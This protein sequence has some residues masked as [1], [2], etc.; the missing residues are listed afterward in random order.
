VVEAVP[1]D[2]YKAWVQRMK[3]ASAEASDEGMREWSN[4]EL[5]ARGKDVYA[6]SCAACHQPN[7][8][9]MAPAF[10]AIA[11]SPVATGPAE[12]HLALVLNGKPGTS[13]QAFAAQLSDADLAAVV[14]FQRNSF[15]NAT[16]DAVQPAQVAAARN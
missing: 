1:E 5:I 10:P 7:G 4:A 15:G 14:T 3:G 16:G 13:M 9:G 8:Q 11:G 2:E 12:A 6:S